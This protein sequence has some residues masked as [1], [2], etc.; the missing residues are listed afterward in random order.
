M[1]PWT[2]SLPSWI[3]GKSKSQPKRRWSP[4]TVEQ[5]EGREM[6]SASLTTIVPNSGR[7]VSD[8]GKGGTINGSRYFGSGGNLW[9]TDGSPN[10]TV[11][12]KKMSSMPSELTNV[13]G[14]LYFFCESPL[15]GDIRKAQLWKSDGTTEGTVF[16]KELDEARAVSWNCFPS[17]L[18]EINGTACF[19]STDPMNGQLE[20]WKSDGTS[21]GTVLVNDISNLPSNYSAPFGAMMSLNGS[22]FFLVNDWENHYSL[23]KIDATMH[24]SA[25][26]NIGTDWMIWGRT[27]LTNF[28]GAV[29]WTSEQTVDDGMGGSGNYEVNLWKSDGTEAGTVLIKHFNNSSSPESA[30]LFTANGRLLIHIESEGQNWNA[31]GALWSSNGTKTGTVL[32]TSFDSHIVVTSYGSAVLIFADDGHQGTSMW[33]SD[34]TVEGTVLVKDL[35]YF[36]PTIGDFGG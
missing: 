17:L 32:V 30:D 14:I 12:V 8:D 2:R 10:G 18:T 3:R 4:L 34:G 9:K 5:L 35:D 24:G 7:D 36:L 21:E 16:V 22:F 15:N 13:G 29:Y 28:D 6:L 19:L 1:K 11:M 20:V 27:P 33:K 26:K 31:G 23:C 25:V